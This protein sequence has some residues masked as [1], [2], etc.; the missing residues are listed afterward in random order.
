V[1]NNIFGDI[2]SNKASMLTGSIE[3]LPSASVGESGPRLLELVYGL[4][5]NI[6]GQDK[7]NPLAMVLSRAMFF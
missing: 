1:T 3:M 2:L 6:V 5:L 4:V 7:E